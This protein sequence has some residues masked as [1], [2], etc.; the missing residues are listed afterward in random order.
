M[1]VGR[2]C[3]QGERPDDVGKK[4]GG[5]IKVVTEEV[6]FTDC[7]YSDTDNVREFFRLFSHHNWRS[8]WECAKRQVAVERLR[9]SLNL[10]DGSHL[11][12]QDDLILSDS[13]GLG[14]YAL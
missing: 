9:E 4:L 1:E 11:Q 10:A 12:I 14:P 6:G 7:Y 8:I 5:M 13:F 2:G 3:S